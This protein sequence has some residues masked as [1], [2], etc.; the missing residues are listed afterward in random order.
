M[1]GC[2]IGRR[3]WSSPVL[4]LP[5]HRLVA[6]AF[7]LQGAAIFGRFWCVPRWRRAVLDIALVEPLEIFVQS[8]SAA[9]MNFASELRVKLRSLLLTALIRVPST[10][11]SSRPEKIKPPAQQHELAKD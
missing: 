9:R 5:D 4:E 6:A 10:A 1:A 2:R 3:C 7:L 8:S 11:S